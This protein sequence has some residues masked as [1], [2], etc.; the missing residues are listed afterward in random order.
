MSVSSPE[1]RPA[2]GV[3]STLRRQV[4]FAMALSL[5]PLLLM[6][7]MRVMA[8]QADG[9]AQRSQ[10]LLDL[11][12]DRIVSIE[13]LLGQARLTLRLI[14]K[15]DLRPGCAL[16]GQRIEALE[17]PVSNVI[18]FDA[19]GVVTC[20]LIGE[21]LIGE[22]MPSADWNAQLR[23]GRDF[24]EASDQPGMA[25]GEPRLFMLRGQSDPD[26]TFAGS[27][28]FSVDL[29]G[30]LKR[31]APTP[32][33]GLAMHH[34]VLADGSVIGSD[35]IERLPPDWLL[36][37]AVM[38]RRSRSLALSPGR[39]AD[40]VVQPLSAEGVW[41]MTVSPV[42][43][44]PQS[45]Q[46]IVA[47]VVPVLVYLAAL[48]AAS[49]IVDSMVLRW[50]ERIRLRISEFRRSGQLAP[51]A[52]DLTHAS[53]EFQ[54]LGEAFDELAQRVT[55]NEAELQSALLRMRG[56]FRET[57]HRV[58]NN[59]QVMLSML[60]LQG[61]GEALP[62]TQDALRVAAH[63]V[64]MM[65]AV[66]H[67][68]LDEAHLETV[69]AGDLFHAICTQID[70]QQGWFEGVRHVVPEVESVPLPADFA[71]PLAM[72]VLEAF[73]LLCR[74]PGEEDSRDLHL[75]FE[76][77][78]GVTGRLTLTCKAGGATAEASADPGFFLGAFARQLGGSVQQISDN[79]GEIVLLLE[80]PLQ[81]ETSAV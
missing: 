76:R 9:R 23:R 81:P 6:G 53:G 56:A 67:A 10:E 29:E 41:L 14:A 36:T 39:A 52:P 58:K 57:H 21:D 59:L 44:R 17:L 26:G 51:I 66:H 54:N 48:L 12:G 13:S 34:F 43:A 30:L 63:R 69:D 5:S 62:E 22:P 72:F 8:E 3:L 42:Q 18:R 64:G 19:E 68:L 55:A 74:S 11:S 49:W 45:I 78:D 65:A 71:V 73:N 33:A 75:G 79:P 60:K 50:L 25:L 24:V 47:F 4:I 61:R 28:A 35:S 7:G 38:E 80:F 70:E 32:A 46:L 2:G 37:E 1:A 77:P 15:D 31:F 16:I 20:H 27:V 40:V